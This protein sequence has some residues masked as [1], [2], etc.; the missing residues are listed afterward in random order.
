MWLPILRV[1]AARYALGHTLSEELVDAAHDTLNRGIY[2]FSLGELATLQQPPFDPASKEYRT[3]DWEQT[4]PLFEAAISELGLSLP[5]MGDAVNILVKHNI[6]SIVEE[7]VPLYEGFHRLFEESTYVDEKTR[8]FVGCTLDIDSLEEAYDARVE[9]RDSEIME[10]AI[11]WH[12]QNCQPKLD[13][14]WLTSAVVDLANS[15]KNETA[16]DRLPILA[17]ALMDAGCD[18]AEMILHLAYEQ[19]GRRCWLVDLLLEQK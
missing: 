12:R 17:D 6:Q 16:F 3:P 10:C 4:A 13:P 9:R 8:S 19:H 11:A 1:A 5:S 2:S 18:D 7:T 15:I 14:R